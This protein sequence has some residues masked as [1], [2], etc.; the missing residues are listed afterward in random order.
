MDICKRKEQFSIAYI[1]AIAAQIGINHSIDVV[2][3][4]S[5]DLD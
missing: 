1:Q 2:D 4:D 3:D 5:V